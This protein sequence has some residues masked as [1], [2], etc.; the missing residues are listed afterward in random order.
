[1]WG[2]RNTVR[3]P[4]VEGYRMALG[5]AHAAGNPFASEAGGRTIL[6][7]P[8]VLQGAWGPALYGSSPLAA[9]LD[10]LTN[11]DWRGQTIYDAGAPDAEKAKSMAAY[12]YQAWTPS[13][14][15]TPGSYQ[16]GKALEGLANDVRTAQE[17]GRAPPV[18]APIVDLANAAAADLGVQGFTGLDRGGNPIQT[19]DALLA[20]FGVKVRPIRAEDSLDIQ[21]GQIK[22]ELGEAKR[23]IRKQG[24][25]AGE[26][27]ISEDQYDANIA[28]Y[29]RQV[30]KLT[31]QQDRLLDAMDRLRASGVTVQV[32]EPPPRRHAVGE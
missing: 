12:L 2:A 6:G 14:V 18:L 13:N 23:W 31:R 9:V 7:T 32:E 16:Q 22:R 24:D 25:L 28:Q 26:G 8:Q 20:S 21:L 17:E 19:R 4:F 29:E 30:E 10:V 15:L 5:R 3:L 1:M 11:Q 27:R